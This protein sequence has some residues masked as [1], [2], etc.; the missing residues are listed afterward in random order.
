M[1]QNGALYVPPVPGDRFIKD[2]TMIPYDS[3]ILQSFAELT[4]IT[5]MTFHSF[6]SNGDSRQDVT[7]QLLVGSF[8]CHMQD[9]GRMPNDQCVHS[10]QYYTNYIWTKEGF[11]T[12]KIIQI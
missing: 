9:A 1:E 12:N 7:Y 6:D 8:K 4:N 3:E 5:N 11:N 2:K 10:L